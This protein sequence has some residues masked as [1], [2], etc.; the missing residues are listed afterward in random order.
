VAADQPGR[1]RDE[2]GPRLGGVHETRFSSN[3]G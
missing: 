2:N 1:T 3:L